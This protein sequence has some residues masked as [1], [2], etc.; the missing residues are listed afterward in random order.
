MYDAL[1][2]FQD[3]ILD[4]LFNFYLLTTLVLPVLCGK[5]LTKLECK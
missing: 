5:K 2:T 4:T 3:T 1:Y